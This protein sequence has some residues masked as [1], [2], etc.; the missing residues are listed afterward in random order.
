MLPTGDA[1]SKVLDIPAPVDVTSKGKESEIKFQSI[2]LLL[3]LDVPVETVAKKTGSTVTLVEFI[4]ESEPG[5]EQIVRMQSALYPDPRQRIK[6]LVN[7][8]IDVKAKL[9]LTAKSEAIR[10]KVA[11][12]IL[13]RDLGKPVQVTE[14]RNINIKDGD[15]G[16]LNKA[17]Q[18]AEDRLK[19]HEDLEK[20]LKAARQ[21]MTIPAGNQ[22]PRGLNPPSDSISR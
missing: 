7:S 15:I 18:S 3:A 16:Q 12:D 17:L 14:N 22:P 5:A 21:V 8:A 4:K 10:D 20:R 2:C 1:L 6:K 9:M 13:D 19:K 11:T